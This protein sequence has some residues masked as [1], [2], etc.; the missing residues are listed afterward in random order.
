MWISMLFASL[1]ELYVCFAC[2]VVVYT[3]SLIYWNH[4]LKGNKRRTIDMLASSLSL[5][6]HVYL[7]LELTSLG[8]KA[9]YFTLMMFGLWCYGNARRETCLDRASRWHCGLHFFG[10]CS[11]V[12][13]YMGLGLENAT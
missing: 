7:A 8:W 4:P 3:T 10:N 6:Y 13:L 12:V 5:A 1:N 9:A 11:N 2:S